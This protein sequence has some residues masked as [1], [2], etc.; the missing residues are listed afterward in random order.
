MKYKFLLFVAYF[1]STVA[2]GDEKLCTEVED[3]R[4]GFYA[5]SY[6]NID[7]AMAALNEYE[8]YIKGEDS[9]VVER[10]LTLNILLYGSFL[11]S[12]AINERSTPEL[13]EYNLSS[14]C[15]FMKSDA[16]HV[17]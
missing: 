3:G 1:L 10:A 8:S 6:F 15:D 16:K 11:R 7:S 2:Y 9:G 13:R 4:Y 5:E 12:Q 17:H 14:F